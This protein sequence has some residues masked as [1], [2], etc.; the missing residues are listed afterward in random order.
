MACRLAL[1]KRLAQIVARWQPKDSRDWWKRRRD[2]MELDSLLLLFESCLARWRHLSR[3]PTWL[4][5]EDWMG[6][7]I[8]VVLA[9]WAHG[10]RWRR[11][12]TDDTERKRKMNSDEDGQFG[13]LVK[14][15]RDGER[16]VWTLFL[17]LLP[18]SVMKTKWKGL[19]NFCVFLP[20]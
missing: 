2:A 12:H 14:R 5:S 13:Q 10:W 7:L 20:K 16:R 8:S 1:A 9:F 6:D 15:R 17:L 11:R 3:S 19:T 18:I 4:S